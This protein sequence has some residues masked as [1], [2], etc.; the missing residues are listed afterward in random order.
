MLRSN[1]YN[2]VRKNEYAIFIPLIGERARGIRRDADLIPY[3]ASPREGLPP[4]VDTVLALPIQSYSVTEATPVLMVM[5]VVE[6]LKSH[7]AMSSSLV[8]V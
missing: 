4:V 8:F 5:L 6:P 3:I 7:N 1:S 2:S